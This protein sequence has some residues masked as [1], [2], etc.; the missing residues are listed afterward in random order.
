MAECVH[1]MVKGTCALC[2]GKAAPR[3]SR[4]VDAGVASVHYD[5][6]SVEV[7]CPY[8]ED[9]IADL[10]AALPSHARSWDGSRRV[11]V[12]AGEFWDQASEIVER[13]FTLV[14]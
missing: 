4:K 1:G 7:D 11:W 10:K 9:F 6:G 2:S 5:V 13:Y 12:I 14:E 8:N 3:T